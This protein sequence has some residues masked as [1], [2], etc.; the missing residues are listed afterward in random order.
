MLSQTQGCFDF[1]FKLTFQSKRQ[2]TL[3]GFAIRRFVVGINYA[4]V[5]PS[6][7]FYLQSFGAPY[8][9]LGLAIAADSIVGVLVAPIV[10][11]IADVTRRIRAIGAITIFLDFV[12]NIVYAIPIHVYMPI[13]GRCI[14]GIGAGYVSALYGEVSRITTPAE[15][16]R[17][18]TILEGV[19]LLGITIG[20]SFNFFLQ[21]FNFYIGPWKIDNRTAP[22]FFMAILWIL[23]GI[24]HLFT[25]YNLTKDYRHLEEEFL[26]NGHPDEK[27]EKGSSY[28]PGVPQGSHE[29]RRR[30]SL[31]LRS[32]RG[33]PVDSVGAR[34]DK[35][36]SFYLHEGYSSEEEVTEELTYFDIL[37]SQ[38]QQQGKEK[39]KGGRSV[40]EGIKT[41]LSRSEL[42]VLFLSQFVMYF[43]QSSFETLAPLIGVELFGFT[44]TY[45]SILYVAAGIELVVVI[46]LVWFVS[47]H[48]ADRN[49]LLASIAMGTVGVFAQLGVAFS[50]PR[51]SGG[52]VLALVM[53]FF[54]LLA[55]PITSIVGKSLLSK[56]TPVEDQGFYQGLLASTQQLGLISGPLV[57][58][59][60][61]TYLIQF[62]ST[63][64]FVFVFLYVLTLTTMDKLVGVTSLDV[65]AN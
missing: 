36:G 11:K 28:E 3:I 9:F 65:D 15:R 32:S 43:N 29:D 56:I 18:V 57:G 37:R 46:V 13:L 31:D 54:M 21:N 16:T 45:L 64:L 26:E 5:I 30:S 12:G 2:L 25:V 50:Q 39:T 24:I 17:I 48:I 52:L 41:A 51:S 8:Y 20:P 63:S 44:I 40:F 47:H 33:S 62:S 6:L 58:S 49:L 19:R 34:D 14:S 59:A 22:G 35:R 4:I 55:T 27:S 53:S 42:V 61:F 10:G 1:P 23:V 38:R 60:L 7:W